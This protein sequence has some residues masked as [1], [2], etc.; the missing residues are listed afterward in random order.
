MDG[1]YLKPAHRYLIFNIPMT[2]R[3][4]GLFA[5]L[6]DQRILST[7]REL[8]AH[9]LTRGVDLN[10]QEDIC[11][12]LFASDIAKTVASIQSHIDL[13][14]AVGGDGTMLHLARHF[15]STSIPLIGVNL[16][17]LGFLT[18]VSAELMLEE[19]DEILD[20]RYY[21]ERRILLHA[22]ICRDGET[23]AEGVALN[24]AVISKGD[25]GRMIEY[26]W[27]VN[28][29]NVGTTRGDGVIVTTPTGS[30]AYALS[31]GG[32]ILHPTL[33]A[34]SVVPICPHTVSH[35]PIVLDDSSVIKFQINDL[36]DAVGRVFLDGLETASLKGNETIVI[37]KSEGQSLLVRA[38]SHNH[39]EALRSKLGWAG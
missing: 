37:R 19:F 9:L 8:R 26:T 5:R 12:N 18:D 39:F 4:I 30:T 6:D 38:A 7:V 21:T 2:F 20:D 29:E 33:P 11:Y 10:P 27:Q 35:R 15:S 17:R 25:T 1:S 36:A 13:G 34:L 28:N 16:G 14:V 22:D 3:Q 32:P 24:D 23:I 31:A